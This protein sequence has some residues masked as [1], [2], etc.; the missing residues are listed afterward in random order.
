M[1]DSPVARY[2]RMSAAVATLGD[3]ARGADEARLA[4]L[5]TGDVVVLA[6]MRAAAAVLS[7]A[8]VPAGLPDPDELGD[9]SEAEL[10]NAVIGWQR[11]ARGPVGELYRA[12]A[13]D[14][15]RGL[16]RLWA[17]RRQLPASCPPNRRLRLRQVRIALLGRVR[18]RCVALRTELRDDA[19]ALARRRTG[20]VIEYVARR[21]AEVAAELGDEVDWELP[22]GGNAELPGT[23]TA[24][25]GPRRIPAETRL[26]GLLGA[27]FGLG[28]ALTLIRVLSP[29]EPGWPG[30]AVV[31]LGVAVGLGL[32][33]WVVATRRQ[34]ARRV[35]L[36]R[37]VT[38]VVAG[39]RAALEERIAMRALATEATEAV[40]ASAA[41]QV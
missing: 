6:R 19:G 17:G 13:T 21:V 32:G 35:V 11:Y 33:G 14:V 15:A 4:G 2:E 34:L 25:P 9:C 27:A 39:L 23:G 26:A 24:L 12:C 29:L 20:D 38:E 41:R 30:A 28:A 18:T 22:H 5:L 1:A 37:W 10:L 8:A 16:L 7:T 3:L 40:A 36:D 31:G